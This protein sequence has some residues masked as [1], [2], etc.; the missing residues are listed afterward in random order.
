MLLSAALVSAGALLIGQ[1]ALRLCGATAWSWLA[2]AVGLAVLLL[3]CIPALHIPGRTTTTAVVVVLLLIA[4]VVLLVREPAQRPPLWGLLAGVPIALL[5]LVPFLSAG[6]VGSLGVGFNNDMATHLIWAESYGSAAIQRLSA[7]PGDYPLG[8][9]ALAA[10]LA[11]GLGAR[12]DHTFAGLTLA[13]PLLLGWTALGALKAPGPLRGA[14]LAVVV[15]I[16]FF[17]AAYYGQGSFKELMEATF[18]VAVVVL[19]ARGI[20]NVGSGARRWI[21][22]GLLLAGTLSVYAFA[23][24]VWPLAVIGPWI[25]VKAV[26]TWWS[27]GTLRAVVTAARREIVPILIGA[28]V[29]AVLLIPQLP[30]LGRFLGRGEGGTGIA[31]SNI[32]NLLGRI[33]VWP[34]LGMWDQP[35]YRL[36]AIDPFTVGMWSA[37]VIGLAL[38]GVIWCM[39]RGQWVIPLAAG[40]FVLIWAYSDANQSPY[41]AAK[42]IVILSPMLLLLAALPVVDGPAPG[43]PSPSWWRMAAPVLATVLVVKVV[44][45]SWHALRISPV[46]PTAHTD[47]LA[48]LRPL[49]QDRRVLFLG[50]DDFHRWE[51]SGSYV[52]APV[53]GALPTRPEKPWAYGEPIDFD[54][55]PPELYNGYDWVISPRDAAGSV[56]PRGLR[57]VRRTRTFD[58]YR[59]VGTVPSRRVLAEGAAAGRVLRCSTRKGRALSRRSGVA[60]VREPPVVAAVPPLPRGASV[61]TPLRLKPGT[62]DLALPYM[63]PRPLEVRAAGR[64]FSLPASLDRPGVRLPAGAIEVTRTGPVPVTVTAT[65]SRLTPRSAVAIPESVVATRRGTARLVPLREACGR[66]VDWYQLRPAGR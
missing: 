19:L 47:E 33:P 66:Y 48:Q 17:V 60:L 51:L 12:M 49:V 39:R 50:N 58:L 6:R 46:G 18:A 32:G 65:K 59:R 29:A 22:L 23:G 41:V 9:H 44:E 15:G 21:P 55:I 28:G 57:L 45:A 2:P 14:A 35:D 61:T 34:G 7:L 10:T 8:P 4:G 37:F 16:P 52:I 3:V 40:L 63:S 54:S 1:L 56:P 64:R 43:L 36:P 31:V 20:G 38:V 53:P 30:R 62:W 13:L 25:V 24:L 42:A 5:A 11:K 27:H 26:L